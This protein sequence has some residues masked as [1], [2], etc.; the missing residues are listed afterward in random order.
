MKEEEIKSLI[1]IREFLIEK[2]SRC[3]DYK[4][5]KNAI[6]KEEDYAKVLHKTIVGIDTLLK[7]YVDFS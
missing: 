6:M 1:S 7:Q 3:K 5:N 4:S 2:F